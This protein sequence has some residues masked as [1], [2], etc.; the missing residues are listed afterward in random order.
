[1]TGGPNG[2][3]LFTGSGSGMCGWFS[4]GDFFDIA[5]WSSATVAGNETPGQPNNALNF[6]WLQLMRD[7]NGAT[8]PIVVLPVEIFLFEG[9]KTDYGNVLNWSTASEQNSSFFTLERSVDGIDWVVIG[10]VDSCW[11]FSISA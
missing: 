2:L 11:K 3:K 9:V 10:N 7:P 5:N 1:M 4:D 8:C 6:A